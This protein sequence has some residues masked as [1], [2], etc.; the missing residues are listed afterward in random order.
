MAPL[1]AIRL[2]SWPK[3]T[4]K[5]KVLT[6]MTPF[7]LLP[8]WFLFN[9]FLLLSLP[10]TGICINLMSTMHSSM[11]I[12]EEI[13]MSPPPCLRQQG[14]H[15][16]CRLHKSL[17]G[18]KQAS[19]QWFSKFIEAIQ[20]TGFT[21]SKADYSLF[22]CKNDKLFTALLIY[23]DDI[24]ITGNNLSA[25]NALKQFLNT[26][27]KIKTL[28]ILNIFKALRSH[29]PRK[30]RYFMIQ[31]SIEVHILGR[32]MHEPR[33][34]HLDAAMRLLRLVGMSNNTKVNKWLL[35]VSWKFFDLM[36]NKETKN[37]LK[38]P[39]PG[40][41]TLHWDNQ[42]ALHI[43]A[44]PVFHDRTR[45]IEM[46]CHFIRDKILDGTVITRY[47]SSQKQVANVFTKALGKEDFSAMGPSAVSAQSGSEMKELIGRPGSV[48]GLLLRIGQFSCASIAISVMVTTAGFAT[49]TAF[50]YL[51]ASMGLQ[52]LWSL[53]L[54]CLDIY[55]LWKKR[56]L[57]NPILVSL[58]VVGDWVTATL[59]LAA[60]CSCAGLTVLFSRDLHFCK[61]EY[62]LPCINYKFAVA[63][64]FVTWGLT[65]ISSHVMFWILLAS[66]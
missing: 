7:L 22:T 13:Y 1:N 8:R 42:V 51:I 54:A 64:A 49:F 61:G 29:V 4:L 57:Q 34:P 39:D 50:C 59:S 12:Y 63:F 18:L 35:R 24:M 5:L 53:G 28:V 6:T 55:A 40:P 62:H 10:T 43:S 19:C 46:D 45:H 47:I 23:V 15:L 21:Q 66:V 56:D 16:V 20:A 27:F 11:A 3:D 31:Q 25:T 26:R 48:S 36:E 65:A 37:Y 9:V 38:L 2:V 14:E 32:F 41:A 44:N 30:V 58:F 60:A 33:K 52:L 17:Y